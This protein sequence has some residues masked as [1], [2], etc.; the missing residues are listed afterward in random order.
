MSKLPREL[1]YGSDASGPGDP[2][3]LTDLLNQVRPMLLRQLMS[4]GDAE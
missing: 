2:E 3:W 4:R 1:K